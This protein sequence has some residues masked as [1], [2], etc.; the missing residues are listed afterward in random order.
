MNLLI[1]SMTEDDIP[2]VIAIETDTFSYPWTGEDFKRAISEPNNRYLTARA[3]GRV[4]GYCGY[5]G[6]AGEGHICNVAVM[7]EYRGRKIG[8]HMMVHMIAEA[9]SRGITS[10]TLE[11]RRSNT[12]AIK[13]YER[14]GFISEGIR[15]DFYIMPR[16][17]AVIMWRRWIQ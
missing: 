2:E 14:L 8:Y 17:D 15:K 3:D 6:V 9:M 10:L 7:K 13:L 1:R 5:W 12:A 16:E 4:A 11:V